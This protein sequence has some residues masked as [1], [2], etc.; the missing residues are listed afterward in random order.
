[1]FFEK[2]GVIMP[3][4]E[5]PRISNHRA[6][7]ILAVLSLTLSCTMCMS[8]ILA[9]KLW[10]LGPIHLDGGFILFPLACVLTDILVELFYRK[11]VD[12]IV[13]CCCTIN[14][15]TFVALNLTAYLP[16]TPGVTNVEPSSVLGLSASIMIASASATLVSTFVNNRIY[17]GMRHYE[18]T[19]N[20]SKKAIRRRAWWSSFIAHIPDSLLFTLLAFD[21]LADVSALCH[22]MVTSYLAGLAVETAFLPI[23]GFIAYSLRAYINNSPDA[24]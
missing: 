23:T 19:Y 14:T 18:S 4:E 5:N 22:Q 20:V 15:F 1:M 7:I 6:A 10:C 21:S 12:F 11:V 13:V 3:H 17:D 8:N 2:G 9:A 16:A 24:P